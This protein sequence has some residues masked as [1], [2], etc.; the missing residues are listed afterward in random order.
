MRLFAR[1]KDLNDDRG[2][3]FATEVQGGAELAAVMSPRKC[4]PSSVARTLDSE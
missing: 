1:F 3:A 4:R 2:G